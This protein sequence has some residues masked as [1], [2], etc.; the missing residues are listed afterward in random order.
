MNKRQRKKA[1]KKLTRF[2]Q[3]IE[4][5]T[6]RNKMSALEF[7]TRIHKAL[8]LFLGEINVKRTGTFG[9]KDIS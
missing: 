4:P 3:Y 5:K 2:W 9:T 7:G 6:A 1:A 8:E